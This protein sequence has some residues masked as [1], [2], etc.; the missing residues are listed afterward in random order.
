MQIGDFNKNLRNLFVART[1]RILVVN[2]AFL[3]PSPMMSLGRKKAWNWEELRRKITLIPL[4]N[5]YQIY[6]ISGKFLDPVLSR[7]WSGCRELYPA[8]CYSYIRPDVGCYIR[9]DVVINI[10]PN[11]APKSGW[12]YLKSC[13]TSNSKSLG[14]KHPI[15]YYPNPGGYGWYPAGF[16]WTQAGC[17][18]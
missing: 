13:R 11:V 4:T 2:T 9:P 8:G 1:F 5:H 7:E 16:E 10:R 18:A 6:P 12:M 3:Q 14:H 15:G 17:L